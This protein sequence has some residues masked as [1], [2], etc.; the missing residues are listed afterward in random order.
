MI[1]P[2]PAPDDPHPRP[3][4]A[5]PAPDAADR[6]DPARQPSRWLLAWGW[7]AIA[8]G[9]LALVV[10]IARALDPGDSGGGVMIVAWI[11]LGV[12]AIVVGVPFLRAASALRSDGDSSRALGLVA[13]GLRFQAI[14][15]VAAVL[16]FG[17]F[18]LVVMPIHRSTLRAGYYGGQR[19]DL[20]RLVAAQELHK[21]ATGLYTPDIT[22]LGYAPGPRV[23]LRML[24]ATATGW[25][26]TTSHAE[27]PRDEGCAIFVGGVASV[28][29][30]PGGRAPEEPMTPECDR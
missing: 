23:D 7:V 17:L 29:E 5:P 16:L 19:A 13:S 11:V 22:D 1:E 9:A 30:T 21:R 12:A 27:L 15:A 10:S 26:A 18:Q 4:P 6:S 8:V 25:S 2:T 28:P 3:E 24:E 14:A 20:A